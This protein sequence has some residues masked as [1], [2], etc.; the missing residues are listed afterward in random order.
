MQWKQELKEDLERDAA[1]KQKTYQQKT[2]KQYN[3]KR[4]GRQDRY[5][6]YGQGTFSQYGQ[7]R[8]DGFIYPESNRGSGSRY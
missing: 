4:E 1:K 7:G 6:Q 2:Y 8:A 5:Q 3:K